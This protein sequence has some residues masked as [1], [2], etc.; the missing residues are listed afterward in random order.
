MLA[1]FC[2]LLGGALA[3][4]AQTHL[5]TSTVDGGGGT[6]AGAKFSLSGT[7]G[8]PDAGS[9]SGGGFSLA[10]GFWP[11]AQS[12]VPCLFRGIS[13]E[14][15]GNGRVLVSWPRSECGY[16]LYHGSR[17]TGGLVPFPPPFQTNETHLSV[18]RSE[19]AEFFMLRR[20]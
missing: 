8:Q 6:C 19:P 18:I 14:R 12:S 2:A 7:V 11:G 13:L 15:L 4:L 10:G 16:V 5:S 9:M 20:Q 17:A 3:G 1:I